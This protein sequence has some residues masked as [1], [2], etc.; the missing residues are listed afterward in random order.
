MVVIP[1]IIIALITAVLSLPLGVS[2]EPDQINMNGNA[3][4]IVKTASP[5]TQNDFSGKIEAMGLS[6]LPAELQRQLKSKKGGSI[7]FWEAVS[8]CETNHKW[9]DG[10]YYSGGLGMAQSV[11]ANY[12]GREFA[13]RPSKATKE[14]QII[15]ANRTAFFGFQTK[16]VFETLEDRENNKPFFRPAQGWKSMT[17]WGKGCVN[18]KTRKPSRDRYTEAGMAEWKKTRPAS[19]NNTN[20][21][22]ASVSA[23]SVS[24]ASITPKVKRSPEEIKRIKKAMERVPSNKKMRCPKWEGLLKKYELPVKL[25]SYIMWRESRCVPKAIGWNYKQ[26]TGHWNCKLAPAHIYRKCKAVKSY[27][28]GLLQINSSWSTLTSEV[29]NAP[30]G[31]MS[32]LLVPECNVRIS[33][34]LYDEARGLTNWGFKVN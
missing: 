8:W 14:E 9:N 2:R 34:V 24:A 13:P 19:K 4:K 31:D 17:K 22:E 20:A 5:I 26:G 10:G 27:D 18:W 15:V 16:T 11:W 1:R 21:K 28:S 25:Y 7:K 32:V 30:Y 29:C 23:A 6:E 12:G 33:A 3:L